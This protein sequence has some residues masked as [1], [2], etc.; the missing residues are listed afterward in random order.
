MPETG[1]LPT[2][3][4][5][6]RARRR[7]QHP[8]VSVSPHLDVAAHGHVPGLPVDLEVLAPKQVEGDL[9]G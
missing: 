8:H 7:P 4:N 3:P 2:P 9:G 1:H 6:D 5:A